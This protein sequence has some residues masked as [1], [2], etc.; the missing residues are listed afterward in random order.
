MHSFALRDR[1]FGPELDPD[2]ELGFEDEHSVTLESLAGP[3]QSLQ[4]EY[5]FGDGWEH[6]VLI[7]K[8]I[9]SDARLQY[10]VCIG[11]ARACP[12]EDC[13]GVPGYERLLQAIGNP[14]DPEHDEQ[15]MWLGGYFD[16][17]GFDVNRTNA[18]IRA[19]KVRRSR[20]R[21]RSGMRA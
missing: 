18:A 5:D 2:D 13:G 19:L 12:P 8:R 21:E 15:V 1:T 11:G 10:P 14:K 3:R 6:E 16:P 20:R 9:S 17:D 7:E 4:Y